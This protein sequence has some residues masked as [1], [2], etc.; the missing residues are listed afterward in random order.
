MNIK[1]VRCA[2]LVGA[3]LA[4]LGW[5]Q[6]VIRVAP[7][8][9][10]EA[11]TTFFNGISPA[12]KM[13][14]VGGIEGKTVTGAPYSADET[15]QTVQT[16]ADGNRIVSTSKSKVY[17]D[18]QGRR[19]VEQ[20]MSNIGSLTGAD[21]QT[22]VMIDDP[23]TSIHYTLHPD[24]RTAEKV[25]TNVNN[26]ANLETAAKMKLQMETL[27]LKMR[28]AAKGTITAGVLSS[29]SK[30]AAEASTRQEE[31]LGPQNLEGVLVQGKR[32]TTTI[33]A[34][35]IGNDRAIQIVDERW[36]SPE[37]QMNIMT[38]H[39]DPRMGETVF[40]VTGV[41]RAN[42]DPTLFQLP[43]DYQVVNTRNMLYKVTKTTTNQ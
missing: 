22:V 27:D 25:E 30:L 35:A 3:A 36:Y 29:S 12:F 19:R 26:A 20:T 8:M 23:T 2:T 32:T 15:T 28:S 11:A 24:T 21:S 9:Q 37:L 34:G 43:A 17:R 33:P 6:E 7:P 16:L 1:A 10:G 5:S 40:T 18:Q 41:S 42:P 39:N 31:D 4:S 14:T 38:K 13:F